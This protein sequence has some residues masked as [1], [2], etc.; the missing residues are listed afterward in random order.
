MQ[1]VLGTIEQV[2]VLAGAVA[3]QAMRGILL[4]LAVERKD[5]FLARLDFG[6]IA[7]RF[8]LGIGVRL[9]RP[10][11][12]LATRAELCAL[13][14]GFRMD[15]LGELPGLVGMTT[16]T[17][18]RPHILVGRALGRRFPRD[19]RGFAGR[20]LLLGQRPLRPQSE[21]HSQCR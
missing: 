11:T 12:G 1:L 18:L 14:A 5:E 15:R 6:G 9:A 7:R 3:G 17:G 8:H 10:V 4:G 16:G 20:G 21:D 13:D 19:R 2:L